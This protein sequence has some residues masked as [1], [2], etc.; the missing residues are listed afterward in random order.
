MN[1]ITL[2]QDFSELCL[3][4]SLVNLEEGPRMQ[5]APCLFEILFSIDHF[6]TK[7]SLRNAALNSSCLL[8]GMLSSFLTSHNVQE[9]ENQP[10]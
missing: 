3:E 5:R 2:Q 1:E 6:A 8:M 7:L 4:M 10:L 9:L